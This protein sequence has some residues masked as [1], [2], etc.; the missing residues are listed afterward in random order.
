MPPQMRGFYK[1]TGYSHYERVRKKLRVRAPHGPPPARAPEP[2]RPRTPSDPPA[3]RPQH[4][5]L[6]VVRLLPEGRQFQGTA[7]RDPCRFGFS[8][9]CVRCLRALEALGVHR[10]VFST[11]LPHP[12]SPAPRDRAAGGERSAEK[13]AAESPPCELIGYEV[14]SVEELLASDPCSSRGDRGAIARGALRGDV[15]GRCVRAVA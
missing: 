5:D 2:T 11:G 7:T 13:A 1:A 15:C 8:K 12:T 6:Y 3:P 4:C 10:I 14:S 9:P